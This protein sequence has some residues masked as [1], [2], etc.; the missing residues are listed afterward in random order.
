MF[1]TF[2]AHKYIVSCTDDPERAQRARQQF[3]DL[4]QFMQKAAERKAPVNIDNLEEA[5]WR[6]LQS[7]LKLQKQAAK[8]FAVP[9]SIRVSKFSWDDACMSSQANG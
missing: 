7:T 3:I 1:L 2:A 4:V 6:E 8:K 5:L 9:D